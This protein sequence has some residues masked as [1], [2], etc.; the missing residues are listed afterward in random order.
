MKTSGREFPVRCLLSEVKGQI[1][2]G[3]RRL[4][5]RFFVGRSTVKLVREK[6]FQNKEGRLELKTFSSASREA[7]NISAL[8]RH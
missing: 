2:D 6:L 7:M 3:L 1:R 4:R 8:I 5:E